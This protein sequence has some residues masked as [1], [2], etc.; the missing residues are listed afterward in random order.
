MPL[1]TLHAFCNF[2]IAEHGVRPTHGREQ[3]A[4][5]WPRPCCRPAGASNMLSGSFRMGRVYR[6]A[7][8]PVYWTLVLSNRDDPSGE[9]ARSCA[10]LMKSSGA[11]SGGT[12]VKWTTSA[13]ATSGL[14][15]LR[16]PRPPVINARASATDATTC[17]RLGDVNAPKRLPSREH[18]EQH[19][20]KCPDVRAIVDGRAYRIFRRSAETAES[21]SHTRR[22]L[23]RSGLLPISPAARRE[24]IYF[25]SF[26]RQ[27]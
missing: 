6:F 25:G 4:P 15:T 11:D 7:K 18:L 21:S 14:V 13:G 23:D 16:T 27:R 8:C 24:A 26:P 17:Q 10:R 12:M 5:L 19:H 20:A 3:T 22:I 1:R 9:T 2:R